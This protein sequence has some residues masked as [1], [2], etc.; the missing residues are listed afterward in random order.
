MWSW[1]LQLH[2]AYKQNT[3]DLSREA[4]VHQTLTLSPPLCTICQGTQYPVFI[5]FPFSMV[6]NYT[7]THTHTQLS[8]SLFLL[9]TTRL[10]IFLLD[11]TCTFE[12]HESGLPSPNQSRAKWLVRCEVKVTWDKAGQF[13]K[14][15]TR[16]FC[17]S[18]HSGTA[19]AMGEKVGFFS[20]KRDI[21][22]RRGPFFSTK[23]TILALCQP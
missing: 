11:C 8:Q 14:H 1:L 13:L 9:K 2:N 10:S 23:W 19:S 3:P 15:K 5:I 21:L 20:R 12:Q 22:T 7:H 16:P 6:G 4:T 17:E 18:G